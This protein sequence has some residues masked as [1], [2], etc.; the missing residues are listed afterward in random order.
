[1]LVAEQRSPEWF[2]VRKGRITS[3]EIW[4][5]M[6]S[7]KEGLGDVAKSYLLERV[8][9]KL[10]GFSQPIIGPALDWGTDLEDTA[11]DIYAAATGLEV[12][13]CS[14]YTVSDFYG[15]TPD[16]LV[17]DDGVLEIKCP[18]TSVNHFKY[19]L[20]SSD[21]EF[22]K[23]SAAYYYQCISHMAV[24]GRKWCD[25]IS[26]DPRVGT[27]Y[28]LFIYRLGRDE[29]EIKNMLERVELASKYM[30]ELVERLPKS[31]VSQ[32]MLV[33]NEE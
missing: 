21:A 20:I 8:S 19:G 17:G 12:K 26:F 14:F 15:G 4:K 25:F 10:G 31:I 18:Y 7:K 27:D 2:S 5:I 1:M 32:E 23:T 9:E 30:V 28:M 16:S 11:R 22:K 29:D 3:S 6:G 13:P 24:T 33:N